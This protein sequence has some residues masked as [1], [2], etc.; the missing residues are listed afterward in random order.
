MGDPVSGGPPLGCIRIIPPGEGW[1]PGEGAPPTGGV[2][3]GPGGGGGPPGGI[4][5]P[6]GGGGAEPP[7]VPVDAMSLSSLFIVGCLAERERPARL[8]SGSGV[9]AGYD[10]M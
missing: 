1:G 4:W 5:G 3:A 8:L 10:M 6:E 9:S 2:L 7:G